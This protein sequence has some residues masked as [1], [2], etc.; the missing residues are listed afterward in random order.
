MTDWPDLAIAGITLFFAWRGFRNGFI[1]ELAG[2]VAIA[3]AVFAAFRYPGSFDDAIGNTVRL[4]RA[5]AHAAGSVIFAVIAYAIVVMLACV[6]GR[7]ASLPG[8]N[9]INAIAGAAVGVGKALL[10]LWVVLYVMLFFPLSADVPSAL[11]NAPLV[12]MLVQSNAG[13]D[14]M[15]RKLLPWFMFPPLEPLFA[16]HHV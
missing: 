9:A 6:L 15:V 1:S 10:V 3:I 8:I 14:D 7:I 13:V 5:P 4:G 11:H 2:P 12:A 16:R